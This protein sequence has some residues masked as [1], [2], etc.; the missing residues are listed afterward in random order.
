MEHENAPVV[1]IVTPVYNVEKFITWTMDSVRAQSFPDWELLLVEDGSKDGTV[2]VI[3]DYLEKTREDRI[4]LIRQPQNMGA[5]KARNRGV[6]EARGR[7]VAYVDADDL[8]EP[9]KL[10]HQLRFMEE[11]DAAFSFTGYEFADENGKGL[12][13]IVRVPEVIDYKEALKNTTIFT[14]TVMFDTAKIPKEKLEMPQIKSEDTA[15]WWRVLRSGHIA[16]GLDENLV[17]YRRAGKTLSSN[18]LEAIRRIWNLYRIAEGMSIPSSV[19][20]FCFWAV[21]AVKRRI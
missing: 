8:W 19:Y 10:E 2:S 4:R 1:S 6:A 21:R 7:Y 18:K 9:L 20:H 15:L 13:K 12:G 14:S 3:E 5:A 11:K 17:K 16:Y